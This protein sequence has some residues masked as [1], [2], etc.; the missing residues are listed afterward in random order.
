MNLLIFYLIFPFLLTDE[1]LL[2]ETSRISKFILLMFNKA[3]FLSIC[4]RFSCV[5]TCT[6]ESHNEIAHS[7][8]L[9]I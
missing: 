9:I 4:V 6:V 3:L 7:E 1:D 5:H 2:V 8:C